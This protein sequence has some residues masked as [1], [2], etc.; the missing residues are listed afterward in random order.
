MSVSDKIKRIL[1]RWYG[2]KFT[3]CVGPTLIEVD[4]DKLQPWTGGPLKIE[5]EGAKEADNDK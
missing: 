1:K 4:V 3:A 2:S 5:H